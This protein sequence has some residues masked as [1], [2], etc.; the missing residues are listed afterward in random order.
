MS[1][2]RRGLTTHLSGVEA[3]G[4]R[5]TIRLSRPL[6]DLD[7]RLSEPYFCAVPKDTPAVP[8]GL[9]DPIPSAGPYYIAGSGGGAFTVLRRNPHYPR[10]TRGKFEAFV[11]NFN[12]DP[13]RALEAIRRGQA[14]YA[15][16]YDD[17][18]AASLAA[19]L[20]SNGN[21]D[22]RSR[23][24]S[25]AGTGDVAG[26]RS[27]LVEFFGPRLGCRSHSRLY[28]G[29]NLKRLCAPR[30]SRLDLHDTHG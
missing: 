2:Y 1:A 3:A 13:R 17:E 24:S 15:A 4:T 25:H 18:V 10:P 27:Q 9:Q 14:D 26:H 6:A 28:A 8:T 12:V 21:V 16:F 19:Q 20:A 23:P 5:L 11:Y 29:L 7:A 30:G 22:V